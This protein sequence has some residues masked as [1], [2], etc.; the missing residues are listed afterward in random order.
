MIRNVDQAVTDLAG[1]ALYDALGLQDVLAATAEMTDAQREAIAAAINKV[2]RPALTLKRA[3]V[4][5]LQ[6]IFE[7]ERGLDGEKKLERWKLAMKIHL[8]GE[9]DLTTDEIVLVKRLV[10]KLYGPSVVG[11][12]WTALEADKPKAV[13]ESK[14]A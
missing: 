6:A 11:P 7:D 12:V 5:A 3:M 4:N 2:G 10:G 14:A 1:Q 9:V 8:G 13:P